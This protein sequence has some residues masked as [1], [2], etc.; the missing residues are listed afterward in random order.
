V[1]QQPPSPHLWHTGPWRTVEIDGTPAEITR[2]TPCDLKRAGAGPWPGVVRTGRPRKRSQ[3]IP[4]RDAGRAQY[5]EAIEAA[6]WAVAA[7]E[8]DL[9]VTKNG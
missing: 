7:G 1:P 2:C 6:G 5:A 4:R 8:Y 9:A 3:T